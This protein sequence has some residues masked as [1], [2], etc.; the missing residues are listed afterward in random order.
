[1]GWVD[2]KYRTLSDPQFRA[3]A[4]A[5]DGGNISLWIGMNHPEAFG[6]IAAYSSNV[7]SQI[8]STFQNGPLLDLDIYLDIGTYDLSVLIPLVHDFRFILE[9][10]GYNYLFY[11]W[12]EGHSW[13]SW[14]AHIDNSLQFFFPHTNSVNDFF[15][16]SAL[17]LSQNY[18]NPT[19]S[20]TSIS[21]SGRVGSNGKLSLLDESGKIISIIWVGKFENEIRQ[22]NIDVSRFKPGIYFCTLENEMKTVV[23]KLVIQ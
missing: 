7:I 13:G 6:K 23:R 12:H 8:S 5:S 4:G 19:S 20:Y 11:E 3:M 15:V 17:K 18:P 14:R 9:T 1:M 16:D 22:A 2:S 10:K 21:F